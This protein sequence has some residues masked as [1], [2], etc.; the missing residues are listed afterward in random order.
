MTTTKVVDK[1]INDRAGT[2]HYFVIRYGTVRYGTVRY[3]TVRYGTVRYGT[4]RY[5]TVRY[6]TVR[7]GTVR[8]GNK[9]FRNALFLSPKWFGIAQKRPIFEYIYVRAK[10]KLSKIIITLNQ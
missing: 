5:G 3:G 10:R 9:A 8:Y 6:G 2:M 4:V 7:Y 1:G